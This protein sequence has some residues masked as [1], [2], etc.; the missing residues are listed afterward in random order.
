MCPSPMAASYSLPAKYGGEV[1][2]SATEDGRTRSAMARA[3][4]QWIQSTGPG[5]LT[6]ASSDSTGSVK[7]A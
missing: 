1:T 2:I 3:S 4:P 5:W 7:R 6:V